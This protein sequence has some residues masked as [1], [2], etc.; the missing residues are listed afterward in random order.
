MTTA[1]FICRLVKGMD[2]AAILDVMKQGAIWSDETKGPVVVIFNGFEDDSREIAEI[3][4][5]REL[6]RLWIEEG[7]V[8][9]TE[10]IDASY[11]GLT[12]I[13][14]LCIDRGECSVVDRKMH[15]EFDNEVMR[16]R[17]RNECERGNALMVHRGWWRDCEPVVSA[18][19]TLNIPDVSKKAKPN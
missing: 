11:G 6:I 5:A 2:R 10:P 12:A 4:E 1:C 14:L 9:I 16:R 17:Y 8:S 15:L 13:M 3:P 7:G 19:K 18:S